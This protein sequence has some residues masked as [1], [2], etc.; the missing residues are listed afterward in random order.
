[1]NILVSRSEDAEALSAVARATFLQTFAHEVGWAD[2]AMRARDEDSPEAF[3]ARVAEGSPLWLARVEKTDAP[4]G[5]AMLCEPDLPVDTGAEDVELKRIY[6]L[7]RFHGTGLG[8]RLL[9][10][11]EAC[12]RAEGRARMLL[13]VK[14]DNPSVDWYRRRDFE[15]VGTRRFR[16]GRNLFDDLVMAKAL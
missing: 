12:A 13:G 7:H 10:A 9:S 6:V 15:V 5:F 3:R 14:D 1:M 16:V 11:A 8:A 4:V 2:I